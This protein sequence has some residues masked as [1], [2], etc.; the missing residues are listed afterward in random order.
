MERYLGVV[1]GEADGDALGELVGI[2]DG[3]EV[4][5]DELGELVGICDG[6]DV[7]GEEEGTEVEGDELGAAEGEAVASTVTI[8]MKDVKIRCFSS[9]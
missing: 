4:E 7:E 1:L 2:C 5:G 8:N 3:T 9:Y 6:T